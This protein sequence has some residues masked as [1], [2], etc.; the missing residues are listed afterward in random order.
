[1]ALTLEDHSK[2]ARVSR[3]DLAQL[4]FE[5]LEGKEYSA[6]AIQ[7]P[8]I[9]YPFEVR[10]LV[11]VVG[12]CNASS[13]DN[14]AWNDAPFRYFFLIAG[15]GVMQVKEW[16]AGEIVD[17][18]VLEDRGLVDFASE[19]WN[20]C[21]ARQGVTDTITVLHEDEVMNNAME[22]ARREFPDVLKLYHA[23]KLEHFGLKVGIR[24]GKN[25]EHFWLSNSRI[26]N[27]RL[28]GNI[29]GT[30]SYVANV[31]ESEL[32]SVDPSNLSDWSYRT[33]GGGKMHGSYT[34]RAALPTMDPKVAERI[35]GILT[36]D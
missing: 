6:L 9:I 27:G 26:E 7:M 19:I 36:D 22:R 14:P 8:E 23:G 31:K 16:R 4:S 11:A 17:Q 20:R 30:P 10:Y 21:L 1:M 29:Q 13:F 34:L 24:D 15:L 2:L 25:V 33:E 3:E 18:G 32:V 12:P 35:R 28:V 5:V